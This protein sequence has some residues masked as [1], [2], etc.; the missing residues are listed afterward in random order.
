MQLS[1]EQLDRLIDVLGLTAD[2][3]TKYLKVIQVA[4]NYKFGSFSAEVAIH[5]IIE[6]ITKENDNE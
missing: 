4:N 3:M 5:E 1:V 2:S 6:I